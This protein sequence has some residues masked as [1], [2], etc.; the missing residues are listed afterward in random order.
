M[1]RKAKSMIAAGL[2]LVATGGAIG[3]THTSRRGAMEEHPAV[4]MYHAVQ[5]D[6]TN[7]LDALY[8]I[9]DH[10]KIGY[11]PQHQR[12]DY[13]VSAAHSRVEQATQRFEATKGD[14]NQIVE[15]HPEV[16][17][18]ISSSNREVLGYVGALG[19]LAMI[20]TGIKRRIFS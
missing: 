12:S 5:I 11:I 10:E 17:K 6:F 7:N 18:Y 1:D 2:L 13:S 20:F 14:L 16:R 9:P 19:G 8:R 3:A 4:K 15:N